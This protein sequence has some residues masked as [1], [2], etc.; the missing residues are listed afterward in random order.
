MAIMTSLD[1]PGAVRFIGAGEGGSFGGIIGDECLER[2]GMLFDEVVRRP[3]SR[4]VY[5]TE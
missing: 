4:L 3:R 5:E 2:D 1:P